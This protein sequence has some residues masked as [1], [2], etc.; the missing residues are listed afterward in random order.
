ML[1]HDLVVWYSTLTT[2]PTLCWTLKETSFLGSLGT[3]RPDGV[4][5]TDPAKLRE[6]YV[7]CKSIII[8]HPKDL[9]DFRAAVAALDPA[10]VPLLET[11][12]AHYVTEET[13]KKLLAK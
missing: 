2:Q 12:R 4:P 6:A 3:F 11:L 9:R 8:E 10:L 7:R 1:E 13:I 5:A